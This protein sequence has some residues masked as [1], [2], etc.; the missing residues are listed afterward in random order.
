MLGDPLFEVDGAPG[1]DALGLPPEVDLLT[2][3]VLVGHLTPIDDV[4]R[5][6]MG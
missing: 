1:V 6:A 2:R 5:V 3:G 4:P